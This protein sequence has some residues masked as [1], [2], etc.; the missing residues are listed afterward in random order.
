VGGNWEVDS[1]KRKAKARGETNKPH[2]GFNATPFRAYV[3][4]S[5]AGEET[6]AIPAATYR[7][8]MLGFCAAIRGGI[9][10]W[11]S[12]LA[13]RG[14]AAKVIFRGIYS[15]YYLLLVNMPGTCRCSKNAP[16]CMR[17]LL[18]D[19]GKPTWTERGGRGNV[20]MT[21]KVQL[22]ISTHL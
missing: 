9:S 1:R 15:V 5:I 8:G 10:E 11:K 4:R 3:L 17:Y 14:S 7:R 16:T 2:S 12:F 21:L 6:V 22:T 20:I 13:P 19:M 18:R